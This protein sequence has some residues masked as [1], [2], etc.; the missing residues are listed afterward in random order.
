M[1]H[2]L[3]SIKQYPTKIYRYADYGEGNQ[4]GAILHINMQTVKLVHIR[5][6]KLCM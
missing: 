6:C 4:L 2:L 1:I 3:K 5:T